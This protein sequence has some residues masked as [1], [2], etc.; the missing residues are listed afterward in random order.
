MNA[1]VGRFRPIQ[2]I[3]QLVLLPFMDLWVVSQAVLLFVSWLSWN[4]VSFVIV[5]QTVDLVFFCCYFFSI[6]WHCF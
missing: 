1:A 4:L 3:Q 5:C 6:L 2:L